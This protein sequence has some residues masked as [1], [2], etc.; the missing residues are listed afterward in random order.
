MM[1]TPIQRAWLESA[2]E[3]RIVTVEFPAFGDLGAVYICNEGWAPLTGPLYEGRILQ[4]WT[5]KRT[6]GS[7]L[8]GGGRT[9][10][11]TGDIEVANSDGALGWLNQD[12]RKR[13]VTIRW[14]DP[15]WLDI[16]DHIVIHNGFVTSLKADGL[17]IR[18]ILADAREEL[19]RLFPDQRWDQ[20]D[21]AG[22]LKSLVVGKGKNIPVVP[23]DAG[24]LVFG[25]HSLQWDG[26]ATA[27]NITAVRDNGVEL[28]LGADWTNVSTATEGRI[29]LDNVNGEVTVDIERGVV[30][31]VCEMIEQLSDDLGVTFPDIDALIVYPDMGLWSMESRPASDYF[32]M[33]FQS[34]G[35]FW[36]PLRDSGMGFGFVEIGTHSAEYDQRRI[37]DGIRLDIATESVTNLKVGVR[38]TWVQQFQVAEIQKSP[39]SWQSW[40]FSEPYEFVVS[41]DALPDD[42]GFFPIET[43]LT[44]PAQAETLAVQWAETLSV[45]RWF[46][47]ATVLNAAGQHELGDTIRLAHDDID[48]FA[49][50]KDENGEP[51]FDENFFAVE[52]GV[53]VLILGLEET[54]PSGTTQ[55]EGWF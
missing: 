16:T 31:G 37:Q 3:R 12:W 26:A 1:L 17:S 22:A 54:F 27:A 45:R 39:D 14:G 28:T 23:L 43:L 29:D 40:Q 7:V 21:A 38:Q 10:I 34:I 48:F 44:D 36:F 6:T 11:G 32:D 4:P 51:I 50:L 8:T 42:D 53:D 20:T 49:A 24:N 35:G 9:V 47:S 30:D 15:G 5:L 52:R 18:V 25:T 46:P 33:V 19:N 41:N 13:P 55:I 2:S